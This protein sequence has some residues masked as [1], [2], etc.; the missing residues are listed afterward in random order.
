MT[1]NG[2]TTDL[3]EDYQDQIYV[4]QKAVD[5]LKAVRGTEYDLCN[6]ATC[7]ENFAGFSGTSCDWVYAKA[8]VKYAY[9]IELPPD[10]PARDGFELP[11]AQIIPTA[12]ETWAGI[13][14]MA[15]EI[16]SNPSNIS[17]VR[18]TG[19]GSYS[20]ANCL[21][22]AYSCATMFLLLAY[23]ARYLLV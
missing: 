6:A 18:A 21:Q 9:T 4:G 23:Y 5:A 8:N 10:Y 14:A 7:F 22:F 1:P 3:P 19:E 12:K 13:T 17:V 15:N 11:I 2:Y 16:H 20:K